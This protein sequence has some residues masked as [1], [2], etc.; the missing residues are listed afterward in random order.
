[1]AK[2]QKYREPGGEELLFI[3]PNTLREVFASA[4]SKG[5]ATERK[6]EQALGA[7]LN[8]K[9]ATDASPTDIYKRDEY[10]NSN[11]RFRVKCEIQDR[12]FGSLRGGLRIGIRVLRI[13][14]IKVSDESG[15]DLQPFIEVVEPASPA[16]SPAKE[17]APKVETESNDFDEEMILPS[18]AR[19]PLLVPSNQPEP[20]DTFKLSLIH[21]CRCR[22][23]LTCR[24]RWSP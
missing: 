16:E 2:G 7:I 8:E 24:S 14:G 18:S 4:S 12:T 22:R 21:I 10:A 5:V 1:M 19:N 17:E 13:S 20:L 6:L 15:S 9:K 23:L 11:L 3:V